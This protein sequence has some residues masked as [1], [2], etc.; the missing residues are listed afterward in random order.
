MPRYVQP[1]TPMPELSL[2]MTSVLGIPPLRAEILRYLALHVEGATS[3]EIAAA[4]GTRSQTVQRNLE[5]L[6]TLGAVN[7]SVPT[8]R[9][10]HH[11][12]F[13]LNHD[14]ILEAINTS[15]AYI[16]GESGDTPRTRTL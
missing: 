7:A 11:V 1:E 3:G 2:R 15:A 12:V 16:N 10:G 5:Q 6:E 8:P 13:T 4:I 9:R 14:V